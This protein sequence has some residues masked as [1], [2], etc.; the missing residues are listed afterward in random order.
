MAH[1]EHGVSEHSSVCRRVELLGR[2]VK[3]KKVRKV[4]GGL[5][6]DDLKAKQKNT[7]KKCQK[8]S[9]EKKKKVLEAKDTLLL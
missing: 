1:Q 7:Q 3:A 2:S 6:R 5:M 9:M 4:D 8:Q